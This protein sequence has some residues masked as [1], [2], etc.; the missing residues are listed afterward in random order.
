MAN[1]EMHAMLGIPMFLSR[2]HLVKLIREEKS[3]LAKGWLEIGVPVSLLIVTGE[4][5]P[6]NPVWIPPLYHPERQYFLSPDY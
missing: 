1:Q 6:R 4:E 2:Q 3:M 5:R